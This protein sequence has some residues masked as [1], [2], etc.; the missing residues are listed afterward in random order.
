MTKFLRARVLGLI[1]FAAFG[2]ALMGQTFQV[3]SRSPSGSDAVL[4]LDQTLAVTFTVQ[5]SGVP[6]VVT[7]RLE[8]A[9][10]TPSA[11]ANA[12]NITWTGTSPIVNWNSGSRSITFNIHMFNV[13]GACAQLAD[14]QLF[15]ESPQLANPV[16]ASVIGQALRFETPTNDVI[17]LDKEISRINEVPPFP[18]N[19]GRYDFFLTVNSSIT[20]EDLND[21]N[22]RIY[23]YMDYHARIGNSTTV[24]STTPENFFVFILY[25]LSPSPNICRFNFFEDAV[26]NNT[27]VEGTVIDRTAPTPVTFQTARYGGDG[28][29]PF[30]VRQ[31]VNMWDITDVEL[32]NCSGTARQNI[33]NLF[34]ELYQSTVQVDSDQGI[35]RSIRLMLGRESGCFTQAA[36]FF[37][38]PTFNEFHI[39]DVFISSIGEVRANLAVP[40]GTEG[41]RTTPTSTTLK[42]DYRVRWFLRS[43]DTVVPL[44]GETQSLSLDFDASLNIDDPSGFFL[45]ARVRHTPTDSLVS[46]SSESYRHVYSYQLNPGGVVFQNAEQN[47]STGAANPD[48]FFDPG[49]IVRLPY[50]I[51]DPTNGA[52]NQSLFNE[53]G[54]VV[55]LNGNGQID[56]SD[57]FVNDNQA[58]PGVNV[59]I[60]PVETVTDTSGSFVIPFQLLQ[61]GQGDRIWFYIETERTD[62]AT[63]Q[64]STFRRYV[65]LNDLFALSVTLNTENTEL[66]SNY[67]FSVN[68]GGWVE[69]P[70]TDG[71]PAGWNYTGQAWLGE[72]PT[73]IGQSQTLFTVRSPVLPLGLD[74]ALEFWHRPNFTFNQSGG[75]LEY[76]IW[77]ASGS[78]S[79]WSN[80]ITEVCPGCGI[81]DP[82][83]FPDNFNSYLSGQ[84]VWMGLNSDLRMEGLDIP[85][86]FVQTLIPGQDR[87]Q[88]RFLF[89]DPSLNPTPTDSSGPTEWELQSFLYST[90]QLLEDNLFGLDPARLNLN[91]CSQSLTLSLL[92][93]APVAVNNLTFTWHQ[94]LQNLYDGIT[95]GPVT[96]AAGLTVPFSQPTQ[97]TYNYFLVVSYN[98]TQRVVPV[99]VIKDATCPIC[100]TPFEAL[101][102]VL[103][104][105]G[106]G[107]WPQPKSIINC[108]NVINQICDN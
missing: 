68:N 36:A 100:L 50:V 62:Q 20:D 28:D 7:P 57:R 75:I 37:D 71:A 46:A 19:G 25:F 12:L 73:E 16:Q 86:S 65:S 41:W 66:V 59:R 47:F 101:Q 89:Q 98:G 80:F 31:G 9:P 78:P 48:Q 49:E 64:I 22:N 26:N 24:I 30:D 69:D 23:F 32:L 76:R 104:D 82:I 18:L 58:Q 2:P 96:G 56:G 83:P 45:E 91:A 34:G 77:P 29:G 42:S 108:I 93:N 97:G 38:P 39:Q 67:N 81:Y 95:P 11:V 53:T 92:A 84:Q 17:S 40:S 44:G 72:G 61:A 6:S 107:N 85:N 79:P 33:V 10:T 5:G 15:F 21:P 3:T 14:F 27:L 51:D 63:S 13:P 4:M 43:G 35:I 106:Q 99:T 94:S 55:D 74:G 54:Y 105:V 102:Q 87:I 70:P 103:N 60:L 8:V 90:F 88:F 1:A 52:V